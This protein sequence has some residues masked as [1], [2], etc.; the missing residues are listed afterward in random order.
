MQTSPNN[1][2][3][4]SMTNSTEQNLSHVSKSTSTWYFI[5]VLGVEIQPDEKTRLNLLFHAAT[6]LHG[7]E[8]DVFLQHYDPNYDPNDTELDIFQNTKCVIAVRSGGQ[9]DDIALNNAKSRATEIIGCL[10]LYVL[11]NNDYKYSIGLPLNENHTNGENIVWYSK[12]G[13]G[14]QASRGDHY[15]TYYLDKF[16]ISRSQI[17]KAV[18][19]NPFK[20]IS[21][22]VLFNKKKD[23]YD[24][25]RAA[26][27]T[28]QN[29][30]N[31]TTAESQLIGLHSAMEILLMK[32]ANDTM[33]KTKLKR[34]IGENL[35]ELYK[36]DY[37]VNKRNSFIHGG[38]PVT[39]RDVRFA[40]ILWI[41]CIQR[42]G[43]GTHIFSNRQEFLNY[44]I[45]EDIKKHSGIGYEIIWKAP[46]LPDNDFDVDLS[47]I[48]KYFRKDDD[49]TEIQMLIFSCIV[50]TYSEKNNFLMKKSYK[51]VKDCTQITYNFFD[52][53]EE[54]NTFYQEHI[55]EIQES[56]KRCLR[57]Y[58]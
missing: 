17:F 27:I 41:I 34:L 3:A 55:S 7:S 19:K 39:E 11:Y 31:T 12:N 4:V 16:I 15:I 43:V 2:G 49:S 56:T 42:Y 36:A 38:E 8:I 32:R 57:R 9:T 37:I 47:F 20:Y 44:L 25:I 13:Q 45:F 52:T 54:F 1:F 5:P 14:W 48:A 22:I 35:Y 10:S 23:F 29:L 24:S 46:T 51:I 53:Y 58:F 21:D 30:I 33:F 50:N 40:I 28:F 6:L 18:N 26:L